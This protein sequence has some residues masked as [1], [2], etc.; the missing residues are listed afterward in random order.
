MV[1]N[2]VEVWAESSG[3]AIS[4]CAAG[5]IVKV[6]ESNGFVN[7][8]LVDRDYLGNVLLVREVSAGTTQF[9]SKVSSAYSCKYKGTYLDGE[10][11]DFFEA[12]P[13]ATRLAIQQVSI[14]VRASA[15]SGATQDYLD[16]YCF[17]LSAVEWGLS[18]SQ[19]EGEAVEYTAARTKSAMHWTREVMGGMENFAYAI[20][21]SG[22][23]SNQEYNA[24]KDFYPAFCV[25]KNQNVA[26]TGGIGEVELVV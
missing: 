12:L 16:R 24:A 7:Y 10:C 2:G 13:G 8:R 23:R 17:C 4:S 6:P 14:P 21:T 1:F 11:T 18:G 26:L 22:E 5:T 19:F 9:G 3:V 25:A 15:S 20:N